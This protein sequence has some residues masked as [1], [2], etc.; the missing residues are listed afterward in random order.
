MAFDNYNSRGKHGG[1][2][3]KIIY[4]NNIPT[5]VRPAKN[6]YDK[7]EELSNKWN[8]CNS[9]LISFSKSYTKG[10]AK[11][12]GKDNL[13]T[14]NLKNSKKIKITYKK[15]AANN[16]KINCTEYKIS[17]NFKLYLTQLFDVSSC[18]FTN[19]INPKT[20]YNFINIL[21]NDL[22]MKINDLEKI[23]KKLNQS[24]VFQTAPYKKIVHK[25]I[26]DKSNVF[27]DTVE[28]VKRNVIFKYF[29]YDKFVNLCFGNYKSKQD[30]L[31]KNKKS[32][33]FKNK[34]KYKYKN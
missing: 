31:T 9:T 29:D 15:I 19:N 30:Y 13:Y 2:Y 11:I 20:K 32:K 17:D 33:K 5:F 12:G 26:N 27:Y 16:F 10:F 3:A 24:L 8:N 18:S 21:S 14:T 4:T 6:L 34:H 7:I 1:G 22:G 25:V 28:H 23:I